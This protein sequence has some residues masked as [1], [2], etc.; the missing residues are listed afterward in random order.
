MRR[1]P[2][3]LFLSVQPQFPCDQ[4]RQQAVN[5]VVAEGVDVHR[6]LATHHLAR[7]DS[8]ED[9]E[10]VIRQFLQ[11]LLGL[12]SGVILDALELV[13]HGLALVRGDLSKGIEAEI[14]RFGDHVLR[15]LA[16]HVSVGAALDDCTCISVSDQSFRGHVSVLTRL[17]EVERPVEAVLVDVADEKLL[18]LA[19]LLQGGH[20][21]QEESRVT[22]G[23]LNRVPLGALELTGLTIADG[24]DC[25]SGR[26]GAGQ[27]EMHARTEVRVNEAACI[28]NQAEVRACIGRGTVRPIRSSL[29]FGGYDLGIDQPLLDLRRKSGQILV[30]LDHAG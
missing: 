29:D 15:E 13:E 12:G 2:R 9:G 16:A 28:T 26:E 5:S 24:L 25:H 18:A 7:P 17:E 6:V 1:R 14:E 23:R 30:E 19:D 21:D 3:Q 8:A 10:L 20:D 22:L 27:R 11:V 4:A